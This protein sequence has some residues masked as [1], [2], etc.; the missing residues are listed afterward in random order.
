[1]NGNRLHFK[2]NESSDKFVYE[3]AINDSRGFI[4]A[5]KNENE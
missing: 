1:M 3:G 4:L 2:L 5:G